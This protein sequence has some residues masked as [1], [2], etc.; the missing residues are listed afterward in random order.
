MFGK[1]SRFM[2]NIEI[3]ARTFSCCRQQ[4][5]E[6]RENVG[7]VIIWVV[8]AR[9]KVLFCGRINISYTIHAWSLFSKNKTTLV[10]CFHRVLV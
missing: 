2:I 8:T 6:K 3:S 1:H 10:V 4:T 9:E 5:K 7:H